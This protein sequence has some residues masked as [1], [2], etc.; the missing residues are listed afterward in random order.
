MCASPC[1]RA[2]GSVSVCARASAPC[3]ATNEQALPTLASAPKGKNKTKY[4]DTLFHVRQV[5]WSF[6]I[7]VKAQNQLK[8]CVTSFKRA[9][10]A[11]QRKTFA[12]TSLSCLLRSAHH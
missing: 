5:I 4:G 1:G 8:E 2:H 7:C 12:P 10:R 9:L 6:K 11:K 3:T